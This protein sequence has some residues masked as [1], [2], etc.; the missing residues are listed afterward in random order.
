MRSIYPKVC[1]REF[2]GKR[3]DEVLWEAVA[4]NTERVARD[5]GRRDGAKEEH[6][7]KPRFPLDHREVPVEDFRLHQSADKRISGEVGDAVGDNA[8]DKPTE[9]EESERQVAAPDRR[10]DGDQRVA[11][12]RH[13]HRGEHAEED[14]E[15]AAQELIFCR[16]PFDE[17]HEIVERAL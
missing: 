1:D 10:H 11:R 17:L 3:D 9:H 2:R 14:E 13:E 15:R 7:P 8:A 6:E 16:E 4:E 12:E 5:L